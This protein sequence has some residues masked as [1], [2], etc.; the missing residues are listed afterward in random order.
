VGDTVCIADAD[1]NLILTNPVEKVF[2]KISFYLSI[3]EAKVK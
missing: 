2:K 3:G 1:A